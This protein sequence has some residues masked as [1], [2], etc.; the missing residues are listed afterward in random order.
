MANNNFKFKINV[1]L[2]KGTAEALKRASEQAMK[3][4]AAELTGRF[5][6]AISSA[7]WPWDLGQSKRGLGGS[8]LGERA[9]AWKKAKFNT[10]SPRSIVDSGDLKQS[11]TFSLKGLTA[12]WAWTAEYAA[13]VHEGA[14]IHPWGDPKNG[15]IQMPARPWTEAV[16]KG[17]TGASIEVY[18]FTTELS[19]RIPKYFK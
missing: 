1:E 18:D 12:E 8:T 9:K 17:G 2:P 5:D 7:V 10:G 16:L 4:V 14:R 3:E 15:T 11:R 13:A 6:D 19:K